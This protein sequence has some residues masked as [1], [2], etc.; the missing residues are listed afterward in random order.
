MSATRKTI[1]RERIVASL[2]RAL[3]HNGT[4]TD[5]QRLILASFVGGILIDS[6]AYRGYNYLAS[7]FT[8]DGTLRP[9]HNDSRRRYF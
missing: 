1:P 5:E 9:D 7:E 3:A 2:N 4:L 6:D 8:D